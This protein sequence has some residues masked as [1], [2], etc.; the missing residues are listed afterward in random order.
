MRDMST[1]NREENLN[2]VV[3]W[4][5]RSGFEVASVL[6]SNHDFV[7]EIAEK[8]TM[9][10]VQIV[11]QKFDSPFVLVVGLVNIPETDRDTLKG[12]KRDQFND[13]IWEI[14]LNLLQKGVD[15]TV[16]GAENDPDAWE[17]QRHLFLNET[18]L[19]QFYEAYSKVKNSLIGIIWSYKR[20]LDSS[21]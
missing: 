2:Q 6:D 4:A 13:L 20:A 14:K 11:H 19:N 12:C 18:D 7:V 9:L 21:A 16:M 17:V 5:V 8:E 3:Q 15:F 10:H 1:E